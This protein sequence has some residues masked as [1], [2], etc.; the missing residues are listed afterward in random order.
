M[1]RRLITIQVP[2]QSSNA[3]YEIKEQPDG[4]F[5]CSCPAWKTG[6]AQRGLDQSQRLC[7]HMEQVIT[8]LGRHVVGAYDA[9]KRRHAT[10]G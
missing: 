7:K 1:A 8:D 5:W 10:T 9:R 4:S 2:S 3:V 6:A